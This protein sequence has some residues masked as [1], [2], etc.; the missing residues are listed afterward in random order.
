MRPPARVGG[1]ILPHEINHR[2]MSL[3]RGGGQFFEQF[4]H[5]V[6]AHLRFAVGDVVVEG[7][8]YEDLPCFDNGAGRGA[9]RFEQTPADRSV[10]HDV[11]QWAA[12]NLLI[13]VKSLSL[14]CPHEVLRAVSEKRQTGKQR[15]DA[16]NRV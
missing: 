12:I 2:V 15:V 5:V 9:R 13:R 1:R 14:D 7:V 8:R 10:L 11:R 4:P 6:A 3:V 16:A